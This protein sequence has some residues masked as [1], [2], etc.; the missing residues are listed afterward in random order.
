MITDRLV[1]AWWNTGLSP[2]GRERANDA[3]YQIACSI[4]KSLIQDYGV[5]FLGL[6]EITLEDLKYI[7]ETSKIDGYSIFDGTLREGRIQF[8]TG[9][10][11]NSS[12]ISK[13][14]ELTSIIQHGTKKLKLSNR[15]DFLINDDDRPFHIFISHW[16]SH[17]VPDCE[18]TRI[19]LG[20]K[21]RDSLNELENQYIGNK[22]II[23]MGDFNEEPFHESLEGQLLATRDRALAIRNHSYL[24]NP[25]WRYLGESESYLK[26]MKQKSFAGTCF[27][28]SGSLTRWKTVDQIMV[29]SI[30]LGNECWHLNE[31]L[32]RIL[33]L[34][35]KAFNESNKPDIFDHFPVIAT[36]EKH[37]DIKGV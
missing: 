27:I 14:G 22:R 15:I 19:T 32:T 24:Y 7:K 37:I 34:T 31:D 23:V 28:T 10:I 5:V 1:F 6:G 33:Y 2:V 12:I 18:S 35:P 29:S 8:D 16:P 11:F 25:F 9:A 21:M 13:I 17:L 30:F 3:D 26:H 4:V 36:L 20:A